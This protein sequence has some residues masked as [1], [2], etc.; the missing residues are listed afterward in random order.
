VATSAAGAV[1]GLAGLAGGVSVL[2]LNDVTTAELAGTAIAQGNV[3]VTADDETRTAIVAGSV[4]VSGGLGLGASIG[5]VAF[6]KATTADIAANAHVTALGK[7]GTRGGEYTGA[8]FT[9]TTSASGISVLANSLESDFTLAVAGGVGLEAGVSGVLSLELMNIATTADIGADAVINQTNTGAATS[10]DVAVAAR[11]SATTLTL[12]GGF[13]AGLGVGLAGTVD[14]GVFKNTTAAFIDDGATVNA[15]RNVLVNALSNRAGDSTTVS[16]SAGIVAIAAGISIYDYGD[17]VDPNGAAAGH[18]GAASSGKVGLGDVLGEANGQIGSSSTNDLLKNSNNADVVAASKKADTSRTGI[19]LTSAAT[20]LSLPAG[21]SASV[22]NATINAGGTVGVASLDNI[23]TNFTTGAIS[24]GLVGLGAGVGVAT[25]DSTNTA[26]ISGTST[27]TSGN[28]DVAA[29]SGHT[30][31]GTSFAGTG[32]LAAAVEADVAVLSDNSRTNA[33]ID[34]TNLLVGGAVNVNAATARH[35]DASAQGVAVAGGAAVGISIASAN[36]GGEATAKLGQDGGQGVNIGTSGAKAG[37]V[38]IGA[39]SGDTAKAKAVADAGGLGL[40]AEG[41][42]ATATV[43]PTV[44]ATALDATIFASGAVLFDASAT[45][46]AVTDAEG[47]AIAGGIASGGSLAQSTVA[48]LVTADVGGSTVTAGSLGIDATVGWTGS[49][50][51]ADATGSSGAF[52]GINA[53]EANAYN[54][55][56]ALASAEAS[57]FALTGAMS[58]DAESTTNQ[59]ADASGLAVGVVAVG[60]NIARAFS[61]TVTT[62]TLTDLLNVGSVSA[63][64][65][66]TDLSLIANGTDTNNASSTSGSGGVIASAAAEADTSDTSVTRATSATTDNTHPYTL[67]ADGKVKIA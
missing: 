13:A 41:A 18:I 51:S 33:F 47:V 7:R 20:P 40:A 21:I 62:A 17:G 37:S 46:S 65:T 23:S 2:S 61:N 28:V 8:D 27:I 35:L 49:G 25:V 57:S 45:N 43:T 48:A 12:D 26:Q 58:V 56:Q 32:G 36:V 4:G 16:G 52:I 44:S 19:D 30:L 15:A 24:A 14:V 53:T 22:G 54:N 9:T 50:V 59:S 10:Q 63:V 60:G 55:S 34:G 67:Q 31:A 29:T 39:S 64:H 42:T 3:N 6:N 66:G 1:G 11:D 38:T 5:V